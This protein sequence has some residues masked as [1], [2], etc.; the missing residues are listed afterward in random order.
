MLS[1]ILPQSVAQRHASDLERL[2][3]SGYKYDYLTQY[4]R[5]EERKR[6]FSVTN[7]AIVAM[8]LLG[9]LSVGIYFADF[10]RELAG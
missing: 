1:P 7:I 8:I 9:I 6:T 2:S 5:D 3:V 4:R 10:I